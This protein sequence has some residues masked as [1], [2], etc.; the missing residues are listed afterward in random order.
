MNKHA[1]CAGPSQ[2]ML[3]DLYVLTGTGPLSQAMQNYATNA[4]GA[5]L[6]N[7]YSPDRLSREQ[8]KRLLQWNASPHVTREMMV[9][10][11]NNRLHLGRLSIDDVAAA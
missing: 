6:Q 11:V 1:N 5:D 8:L 4:N 9:L 2:I 10:A 7:A 3:D